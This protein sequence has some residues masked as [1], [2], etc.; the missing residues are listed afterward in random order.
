ML[1]TIDNFDN[2][3]ARDYTSAIDAERLPCVIRKLNCPAEMRAW[4]VADTPQFMVPRDGARVMLLR[5]G[6]ELFTGY[7]SATPGYEY[8]GW[9]ERG[10]VYRYALVAFSDESLLDGKTLPRRATF[11]QRTAG[12]ALK[13][14]AEDLAPGAFDTSAVQDLTTLPTYSSTPQRP[15]SEH[16]AAIALRGRAVYRAH[17]AALVFAPVGTV[18][19]A[20]DERAPEFSP[21][22]LKLAPAEHLVNDVTVIGRIEPRAYVKDYFLGDGYTLHFPLSEMPF[23]RQNSTLLEEEYKDAALSPTRWA[24]S[25][26]SGAISVSGGKLTISGGA[27]DGLT[28]VCF[29]EKIELGGAV[30]LQ[31]G[32]VSFSDASEGVLGG[33]YSGEVAIANCVAGF[34]IT[35]SGAQSVIAALINGAAGATLTTVAGHRYALTTRLYSNEIYRTRQTFHSSQH[36]A[37]SGRGGESTLADVRVVLEVHDIDPAN[38]GS[39]VAPSTVLYDGVIGA[40]PGFATYALASAVNLHCS[41]AFTRLLRAVDASVRSAM[42][43]GGYRTRLV[44]A[45][46]EGG[47]CRVTE[48]EL[49]FLAQYVPAS[50]EQITV[51]YRS[52]GRAMARVTDPASIAGQ[53]R[54]GDDGRRGA[55]R[56]VAS[57]SPRTARDCEIA[58]LALLDDSTQ[59]AWAGAYECWSNL[60]PGSAS[61]IFPGD[62]LAV[63]VPSRGAVFTAIVREVEIVVADLGGVALLPSAGPRSRYIIRFAN[64]AAAPLAFEFGAALSGPLEEVTA[65]TI[66][67]ATFLQEP[68]A[69]EITTVNST[70]VT[71]D[72]GAEPPASGGIEVRRSDLGWGAENDRNLVGRF[73]TR[74]FTVPRLSRSQD[75]Y[76]RPY[77]AAWHYSRY[78]T[79]LHLDWPYT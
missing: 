73:S 1:L 4:L 45:L 57:P 78:S 55:V 66:A 68:V 61:D 14:L 28:I 29:V 40:A 6:D 72:A 67:G 39:L 19:H 65:T 48:T 23:T 63:S 11:V 52:R 60:L 18:V 56:N 20:L 49:Q 34:G 64:D 62:A 32:D 75:Y 70:Q 37:G 31:H 24:V 74:I 9:G 41:V 58:A 36:P 12:S 16:A 13:Q 35:K 71:I 53:A 27:G 79:L 69:A 42:Q 54:A 44:G 2:A 77:D 8:L 26:P 51:S 46:I 30:I 25:D 15:W 5:G 47:E 10:P 7:V 33:L 43:S 50:Q 17:D 3:G 76:L 59:P 38:P 22:A 21:D